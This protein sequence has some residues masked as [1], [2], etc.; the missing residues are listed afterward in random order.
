M[1]SR[2]SSYLN[3]HPKASASFWRGI[4]WL[5]ILGFVLTVLFPQCFFATEG[6]KLVSLSCKSVCPEKNIPCHHVS[7][8]E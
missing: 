8:L 1:T 3:S 6:Q 4:L 7:Y 2:S 5:I